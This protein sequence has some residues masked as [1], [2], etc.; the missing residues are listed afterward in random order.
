MSDLKDIWSDEPGGGR[1]PLTEEQLMAYFEGRLSPEEQHEV[2]Q[3]LEQEGM[4]ADAIEGLQELPTEETRQMSR[5]LNIELSRQLRPKRRNRKRPITENRW[6]W[7][8]IACVL[9][10]AVLAYVVIHMAAKK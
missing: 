2:E 8:A 6:A 9:L 7:I 5:H 10:L 3:W 1:K 4:E